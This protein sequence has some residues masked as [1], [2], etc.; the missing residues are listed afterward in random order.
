MTGVAIIAH[1]VLA[2]TPQ[3]PLAGEI[4]A[5]A[6]VKKVW[7][8]TVCM[9]GRCNR[10]PLD[11]CGC[12]FAVAERN[13]LLAFM[14]KRDLSTPAK[15]RE[16]Y[17]AVLAAY[18]SQHGREALARSVE[19][20]TRRAE[21]IFLAIVFGGLAILIVLTLTVWKKMPRKKRRPSFEERLRRHER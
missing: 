2:A 3:H 21:W 1:L 10:L 9:C 17:D 5:P 12:Q 16:A 18:V 14:E 13:R 7:H 6:V 20:P 4:A 19:T 8:E 11:E 15:E